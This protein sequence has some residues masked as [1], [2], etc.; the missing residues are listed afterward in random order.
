CAVKLHA[1]CMPSPD[2]SLPA[3]IVV[4][5]RGE[6][7]HNTKKNWQ[8][9]VGLAYRLRTNTALRASFG[10]FF[11]EWSAIAQRPQNLQGQWP[12]I[13]AQSTSNLNAPNSAQP[14]PSIKGTNPFPGG[15]VL[16]PPTPFNQQQVYVDPFIRNPYSMQWNFG[17][18]HQINRSTIATVNYV[19]AGTRRL[20]IRPDQNT[21]PTPGPGDPQSR[22]PYPYIR[23]TSYDWDAGTSGYHA[24]QTLVDKKYANGLAV[25]AS[26]TWSKVIDI[27]CSGFLGAACFVQ[28]PYHFNTS[29][30]V[31][32]FDLT[33][34][35]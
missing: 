15:S 27:G 34:N 21:A 13:G 5:P 30:G 26:Y 8:P 2:G 4:D 32:G 6:F 20:S 16:P 12:G 19:G 11:D 14:T 25:M 10:I 7:F 28:D 23:P 35:M 1:P 31:A 24:L 22:A 3:H 33:H 17:I 9:R 29:R 18:Q